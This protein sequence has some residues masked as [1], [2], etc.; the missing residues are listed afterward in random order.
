[1]ETVIV[2]NVQMLF[3][4]ACLFFM[5]RTLCSVSCLESAICI[6]FDLDLMFLFYKI[7]GS[8]SVLKS[9]PEGGLNAEIPVLH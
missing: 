2:L 6:K 1:M 9:S 3:L 8:S 4:R 5:L 7:R